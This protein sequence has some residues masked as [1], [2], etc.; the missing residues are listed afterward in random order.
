MLYKIWRN[1]MGPLNGALP[2]PY[3]PVR[4]TRGALVAHPYILMRRSAAEALST[5]GHLFLSKFPSGTILLTPY[6]IVFDWR[7]SRAGPMFFYWPKLLYPN[8]IVF[9]YFSLSLISVYRLVLWGW[10][11]GTDRVYI[12]LYQPCT[13][14]LF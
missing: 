12:T 13:S 4:I 5:T 8:Y 9:Y 1:P 14:D 6:S 11:L 7:V 2:E 3:V 10:G